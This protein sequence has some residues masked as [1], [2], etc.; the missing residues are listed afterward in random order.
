MSALR[1]DMY[2]DVQI[3]TATGNPVLAVPDSAV[4]DTG[5]QKIVILDMGEGA[6]G[7][8]PNSG[9]CY[10]ARRDE[11]RDDLGHG[12]RVASGRGRSDPVG[13]CARQVPVFGTQRRPVIRKIAIIALF[14][15]ASLSCIYPAEKGDKTRGQ[16]DFGAYAP[17]H[18]LEPNRNMTG[19]S[20]ANLWD[21]KVGRW[22]QWP[23]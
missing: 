4:I 21:D 5:T 8:R 22:G 23:A 2:A 19:P 12:V 15:L 6:A 9:G 17:C 11:G 20:L 7:R 14:A 10:D 3:A 16:H 18:S 13:R 1:P